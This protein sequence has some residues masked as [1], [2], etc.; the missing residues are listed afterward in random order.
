MDDATPWT[1]WRPRVVCLGRAIEALEELTR[2]HT[3]RWEGE[4]PGTSLR[5][6]SQFA[7]H[8]ETIIDSVMEWERVSEAW[9]GTALAW[10]AGASRDRR[11]ARQVDALM[12]RLQEE[13]E[14]RHGLVQDLPVT[15]PR[16][17]VQ[18][19]AVLVAWQAAD[20][21]LARDVQRIVSSESLV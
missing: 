14:L 3:Q 16:A 9:E 15:M 19:H 11:N 5:A 21:S 6:S 7:R 18:L 4:R 10:L 17:S 12:L 8:R 2:L 1:D 20:E 13:R